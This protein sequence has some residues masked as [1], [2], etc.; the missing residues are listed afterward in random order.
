MNYSDRPTF[1]YY[2]VGNQRLEMIELKQVFK[3]LAAL[4]AQNVSHHPEIIQ[5]LLLIL[6][7]FHFI[8]KHMIYINKINKMYCIKIIPLSISPN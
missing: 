8:C 5:A 7:S 2:N 6:L 4:G 3:D 1:S